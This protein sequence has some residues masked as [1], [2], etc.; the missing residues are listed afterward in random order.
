MQKGVE[1]EAGSRIF[2]QEKVTDYFRERNVSEV[3]VGEAR[4]Q[5]V[6]ARV[7]MDPC[8]DRFSFAM[9]KA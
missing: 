3:E 4:C 6:K 9:Q 5:G 8:R 2:S 7:N 1:E